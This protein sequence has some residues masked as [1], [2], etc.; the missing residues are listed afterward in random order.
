MLFLLFFLLSGQKVF[1]SE[2][3]NSSVSERCKKSFLLTPAVN[4][5]L[6]YKIR[7]KL[8]RAGIETVGILISKTEA[9]LRKL[10]FTKRDIDEIK[11]VL[12]VRG[13]RLKGNGSLF[14]GGKLNEE[15][16]RRLPNEELNRILS[17]SMEETMRQIPNEE[18][19]RILSLSME[20]R[21]RQLP[22]EEL[23]RTFSLLMAARMKQLPPEELDRIL[24]VSTEEEERKLPDEESKPT[25][26]VPSQNS[27]I[28]PPQIEKNREHLDALSYMDQ[29]AQD[30]EQSSSVNDKPSY[31]EA[32][33][34]LWSEGVKTK[35]QFYRWYDSP[36]RLKDF[37]NFPKNLKEAYRGRWPGWR[38]AL[39]PDKPT[40]KIN[41][42][43]EE[44]AQALL[45][46]E[47]ITSEAELLKWITSSRRPPE[48]P[49]RPW[50]E[51]DRPP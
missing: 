36:R 6:S 34:I 9:D 49:P 20:E 42:M 19:D 46:S 43:S 25:F 51:Y 35:G 44:E 28:L 31:E 41:Y 45:L 33:A 1:S 39:G 38:K 15:T 40:R 12:F 14:S 50:G 13:E 27:N 32:M 2:S 47:S 23:N 3:E 4:L 7:F 22:N 17:L 11:N 29:Y 48:F 18:L 16:I 24:S 26:F 30:Q 37:P 8:K 5:N 21:I 10:G